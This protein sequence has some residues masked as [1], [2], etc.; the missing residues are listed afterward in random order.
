[1]ETFDRLLTRAPMG[2]FRTMT[3]DGGGGTVSPLFLAI[4]QTTGPILD[5]KT[6]FD[7]SGLDLAEYFAEFY[8]N[9]TNSVTGRVKRQFWTVYL[10]WLRRAKQPYQTE[11]KTMERHGSYLGN[12]KYPLKPLMTLCQNKVI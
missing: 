4:C 9:A 7:S 1:M 10:Y 11:I 3:T 2:Y 5:P 8:L 12:S 6:A